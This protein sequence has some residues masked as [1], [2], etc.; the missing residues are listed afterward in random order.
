M[1]PEQLRLKHEHWIFAA[2]ELIRFDEVE[3]AQK[4][5]SLVPAHYR[6]F[7]VKEIEELK[8]KILAARITPHAYIH[9]G[10]DAQVSVE[11]ADANIEGLLRGKILLKEMQAFVPHG[12]VPHIVDL[13]PGEYWVPIGLSRRG[14]VFT[15]CPIGMDINASSAA[16]D[17]IKDVLDYEPPKD[18]PAIFVAH[19][20]IEHMSHPQ[21]L[22]IE[23]LRYCGKWPEYVHLST[24]LYTFNAGYKMWD[25]PLGLPHLRAYTPREFIASA[26]SIFPGYNWEYESDAIQ[27]LRGYKVGG[28]ILGDK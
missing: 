19:E 24:P 8:S 3:L 28:P 17:L 10:C 6:D 12:T 18:R 2:E 27:S 22:S 1:T 23:A 14:F 9:G 20:V 16:A 25:K 21:D 5:L 11:Q 26:Q 4:L 15:Y 7:E 13:G